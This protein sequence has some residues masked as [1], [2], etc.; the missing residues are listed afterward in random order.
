[1]I[2]CCMQ[3]VT[4]SMACRGSSLQSLRTTAASTTRMGRQQRLRAAETAHKFSGT[5]TVS[6]QDSSS[7]V[8]CLRNLAVA[9]AH[10]RSSTL[11]SSP[12]TRCLQVYSVAFAFIAVTHGYLLVFTFHLETEGVAQLMI[13]TDLITFCF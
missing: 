8:Q 6:R 9:I 5:T 4:P 13:T 2:L 10:G 7:T 11:S 12:L 1:M 3:T